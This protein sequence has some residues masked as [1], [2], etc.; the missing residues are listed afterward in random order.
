MQLL[1]CEIVKRYEPELEK[2]Q[3]ERILKEHFGKSFSELCGFCDSPAYFRA[4]KKEKGMT[5]TE[6]KRNRIE[7]GAD[8]S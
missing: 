2:G 8:K 6:Y 5:P 4:F 7:G 3:T 1:L